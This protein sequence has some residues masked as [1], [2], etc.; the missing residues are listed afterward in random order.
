MTDSEQ[1]GWCKGD[2]GVFV[3]AMPLTVDLAVVFEVFDGGRGMSSFEHGLV[4][5]SRVLTHACL[6]GGMKRSVN[7]DA[8]P[9]LAAAA[10][11]VGVPLDGHTI[12]MI[13]EAHAERLLN[14]TLVPAATEG[15]DALT[16]D[17]K[18]VEIK[19]TTRRS[20]ALQTVGRKPDLLAVLSLDPDT[21][22]PTVVYYGPA[23][24]VWDIA[25]KPQK[26]GQRRVSLSKLPP[27]RP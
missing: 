27:D 22:S 12:G 10:R 3:T 5:V 8:L 23:L 16:A 9:E 24:P 17:G 19:A 4:Q 20:V 1:G 21:L 7:L 26:N 18:T 2:N 13:G 6:D 14:L 25:G 15:H 11:K